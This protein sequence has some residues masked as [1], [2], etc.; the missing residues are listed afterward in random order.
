MGV[1]SK[2]TLRSYIFVCFGDD[3]PKDDLSYNI[4]EAD[5]KE[6]NLAGASAV[7]LLVR[8]QV[9]FTI[10]F[11]GTRDQ[12]IDKFC[13]ETKTEVLETLSFTKIYIRELAAIAS[14]A[15]FLPD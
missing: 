6:T 15:G 7:D 13:Q 12:V 11:E 1:I 3:I 8:G 9:I 5:P 2:T 10:Y 14:E 4:R